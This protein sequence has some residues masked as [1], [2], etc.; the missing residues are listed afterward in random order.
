[1]TYLILEKDQRLEKPLQMKL[2]YWPSLVKCVSW[3]LIISVLNLTV[4]CRYYFKVSDAKGPVDENIETFK[5]QNKRIVVHLEDDTWEL[6]NLGLSSERLT[7]SARK[8]FPVL[9]QPIKKKGSNRYLKQEQSHILNEVHLYTTEMERLDDSK[10]S[11]P[12]SGIQK[13]EVYEKDQAATTGSWALGFIGGTLAALSI[14]SLIILLTKESCP[15]IYTYDGKEYHLAGEIYSGSVQPGLERHDY[16]KLPWYPGNDTYQLKIANEVKEIQHT[17]L[18]ELW[19][20]DHD[21]NVD[22]WVDKY[23]KYHTT[24]GVVSPTSAVNFSGRNIAELV[25]DR[26]SLFYSSTEYVGELPLTDGLVL[27]FENPGTADAAKLI[28]RAKNSFVLD[29]MVGEFH[30][31]FGNVYNRWQKK[32]RKAPGDRLLNWMSQQNIPLALHVERNGMWEMVDYYNVIGPIAMKDDI[33]S[34]PLNGTESDPLRLKLEYGNFFWEIDYVGIDFSP[35]IE[36]N[37]KVIAVETA[38]NQDEKDVAKKLL[39]DD[40]KYYIQPE[41]GDHALVT[42]QMPKLTEDS[43]TIYLHSKGWYQVLRDPSGKPDREYLEKFR[44]PGHFNQFV[45][46]RMIELMD[47]YAVK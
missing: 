28:L 15:F 7:G 27:E 43:R 25:N 19:V 29:H 38:V 8:Y 26:D 33:I 34:I 14:L 31:L 46:E 39:L 30:D 6:Y 17:N 44:Q 24:T 5:N 18:M 1:M 23:G 20:F 12:F 42:F 13:I 22:V 4:G 35:D 36:I 40:N 2:H 32:Q 11:I 16:L 45:N 37:H 10:L 47:Q 21:N 3:I 41:I 9:Y